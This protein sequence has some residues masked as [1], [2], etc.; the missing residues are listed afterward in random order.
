MK[1]NKTTKSPE[2]NN[3]PPSAR[4]IAVVEAAPQGSSTISGLSQNGAHWSVIQG[5]AASELTALETNSIACVITSP[6]YYSQRDYN[7]DNQIGLEKSITEYTDRISDVFAEIRRVLSPSGT[8]FLNLGDT[9]Y[10]GKGQPRGKDRKNSARR[11]G[12]RPVDASGLGVPRKTAIGIPWR[13]ALAMIDS[14]WILRSPIIWRRNDAIPEPTAHDRPWRTYETLFLFS[15]TQ[16]YHFDR[17]A[18]DGDEDIWTFSNRR[19]ADSSFHSAAFPTELVRRCLLLGCP[20]NGKVLDPF[21][22]SGTVSVV[23]TQMNHSSVSIELNQEYCKKITDRLLT[24]S[25]LPG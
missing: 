24:L 2:L 12:L 25:S 13:V 4:R 18:L 10:S 19:T 15:K 21:A 3:A 20:I 17:S 22:G 1:N 5:D 6:P 9:Y 16:R 23:A 14:G 7:V 11:F 8:L